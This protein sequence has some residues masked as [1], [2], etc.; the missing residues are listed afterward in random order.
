MA[1]EEGSAVIE[2]R[3]THYV[4]YPDGHK[5]LVGRGSLGT[6]PLANGELI[7]EGGTHIVFQTRN[8]LA[9]A[10]QLEPNAPATGTPTVYDRTADEVTHVV[11]LLPGDI[12]PTTESFYRGA[13]VDGAGIAFEN[14]GTLYLRLDN[15]TTFQIGAKGAKFAGVSD[16]GKRAFYVEGGNLE[17]FD[18]EEEKVIDF[19]DVGDAVPVNVAP[20]GNRAYFLS[21]EAI[22]GSGQN[23][24]GAEPQAGEQN[25]Y[26]SDEG[27]I[28]F[29]GTVTDRDVEGI[30]T[31]SGKIDGLGL[32]TQAV[33]LRPATDPSRLTPDGSTLLFQ[34]RANLDGYDSG[35][36]PQ[37]YRYDSGAE[38]LE[39]IS[40]PPTKLP[41]TGGAALQTFSITDLAAPFSQYGFFPNIRADGKRIFFE[42][43]EPLV[44]SD[45]DEV[46]DV[47]EWEEEGVGSC[48]R[49]G[50]C[51]YL[52]SSGHSARG[53][54]LF[55]HSSSGDDVFFT[56]GDVLVSGDEDTVSVYDARV[57]GGFAEEERREICFG[58]GGRCLPPPTPPPS[59]TVPKSD[60]GTD[61]NVSPIHCPRGKRKAV[62]GN[63]IVCVKKKHRKR[64][65]H[66]HRKAATRR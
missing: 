26:R 13:S 47:Y 21:E 17:A 40:C 37:V 27:A 38:E 16:E 42:S 24:N 25:L 6:A 30:E 33:G 62:R 56:T 34:S 22:A 32:W 65:R 2:N 48:T 23:P 15:A 60:V 36:F 3:E 66:H 28:G 39:C 9:P 61:S 51:I 52:I 57:N 55:G 64:H 19:T 7:T 44:S 41:T 35:E 11:S 46:R 1:D 49:E 29:V 14:D 20:Q 18:T 58:E 4:R 5:E 50:G 31:S 63:Q 12:T 8:F 10:V 45:T 54:Y 59:L 53:N 43:T